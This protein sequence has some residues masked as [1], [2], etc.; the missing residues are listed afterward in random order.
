MTKKSSRAG[1]VAGVLGLA[2]GVAAAAAGYYFYGK[3]GKKH[4]KA[5]GAWSKKAKTE[6]LEKMKNMETVSKQAY[7][8]AATEVLAKYKQAKQ[9]DPK[10]LAAFGQELKTHWQQIANHAAKLGTKKKSGKSKK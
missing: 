2:A 5:L 4:R 9:V 1:K 6:M 10:E 3:D 8:K 7:S